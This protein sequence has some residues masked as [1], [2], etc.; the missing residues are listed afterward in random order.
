MGGCQNYGPFFVSL[1]QYSTYYL[2]YPKRDLNFDNH[3]YIYIYIYICMYVCMYACMYVCMIVHIY[4]YS[5][6]PV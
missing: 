1:I 6:I 4:I 2:G 5:E 3:P